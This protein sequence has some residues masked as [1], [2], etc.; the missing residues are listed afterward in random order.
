MGPVSTHGDGSNGHV[1]TLTPFDTR[2]R[3]GVYWKAAWCL[4]TAV[5]R[6]EQDEH[7]RL[8]VPDLSLL[9]QLQ[10]V[11]ESHRFKRHEFVSLTLAL[12]PREPGGD[13]PVD[14]FVGETGSRVKREQRLDRVRRATGLL[15]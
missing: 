2:A 8:R 3:R 1:H 5:A 11:R 14:S 6:R 15:Q 9:N 4:S 12:S 7:G 10:R 13:K